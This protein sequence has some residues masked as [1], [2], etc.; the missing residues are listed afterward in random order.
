VQVNNVVGARAAVWPVRE[1]REDPAR[2]AVFYR[3]SERTVR[4]EANASV[5]GLDFGRHD[6][7]RR[8]IFDAASRAA[9]TTTTKQRKRVHT[10]TKLNA[11]EIITI[12]RLNGEKGTR[13]HCHPAARNAA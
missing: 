9:L 5:A 7:S 11:D 8:R 4:A 2:T 12:T 10:T 3:K 1:G 6:D 13:W